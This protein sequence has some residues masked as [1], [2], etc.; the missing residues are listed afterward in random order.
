MT[1]II[2]GFDSK[3]NPKSKI[4]QGK[5]NCP[6]P[7]INFEK[8]QKEFG[9]SAAVHNKLRGRFF[10]PFSNCQCFRQGQWITCNLRQSLEIHLEGT[11]PAKSVTTV[12]VI[13][14][15]SY[16]TR[17][18]DRTYYVP[19][20]VKQ[21]DRLKQNYAPQ[22]KQLASLSLAEQFGKEAN[23]PNPPPPPHPKAAAA[24]LMQIIA[25]LLPRFVIGLLLFELLAELNCRDKLWRSSG[26]DCV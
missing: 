15:F 2:R 11:T 3:L 1:G 6:L 9:A 4:C 19:P 21:A 23:S 25:R 18:V 10:A 24:Q 5:P 20:I 8:E 14:S 13:D 16:V 12:A 17:Y 7:L 26:S 22:Q